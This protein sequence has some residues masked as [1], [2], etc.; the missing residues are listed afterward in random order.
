[1]HICYICS[2]YPP[3][4]HGG[5]GSFTQTLAREFVRR[6]HQVTAIGVYRDGATES[7][8][9][10]GVRVV[11][12][13]PRGF[14]GMRVITGRRDFAAALSRVAERQAVDIVEAGEMEMAILNPHLPGRKV[15]R[16][17][18]GPHFFATAARPGLI[19]GLKERWSFHMADDL[20]AVSQYVAE[21]TRRLLGL[22]DRAITVIPN[23]V[24]VEMFAPAEE[25]E[26]GL[27]VFTGTITERKGIRQLLQA[28]PEIV[29]RAPQAHLEI[30]G[31]EEIHGNGTSFQSVLEAS[32]P[33]DL[34]RRIAW[35]GRVARAS[36]PDVLQRAAVC[37][38]PSHMEAMP[39]AWLEGMAV[40]KAVVASETGPGPELIDHGVTGLLANPRDPQSI[41]DAIVRVLNDGELR[42]TL[43]ANARRT[44]VDRYTLGRLVDR[45]LDYYAAVLASGR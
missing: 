10:E 18:G 32:I 29:A 12:L 4:P 17:H 24:D 44:V 7:E 15:L 9:D 37:V 13:C 23:P 2:E 42:R 3:A 16:M 43:G 28:M 40:G 39:I 27:I 1:M 35:K 38:Y 34:A 36:L 5:I 22:G 31:G 33:R 21:T 25:E 8:V 45:N 30:Y 14:A 6:G 19:A 26:D 20:C 11:R 41:A